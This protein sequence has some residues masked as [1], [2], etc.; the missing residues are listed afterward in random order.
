MGD[1]GYPVE[2]G[3]T[4]FMSAMVCNWDGRAVLILLGKP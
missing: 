3:Y 1:D 2:E 4:S